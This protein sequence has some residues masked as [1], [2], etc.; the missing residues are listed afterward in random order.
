MLP[1]HRG[2][3]FKTQSNGC[4]LCR[5]VTRANALR[6]ELAAIANTNLKLYA[7]LEALSNAEANISRGVA[8]TTLLLETARLY[9]DVVR[10]A[11]YD[12]DKVRKALLRLPQLNETLRAQLQRPS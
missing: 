10:G 5:P 7:Q 6:T 12:P 4:V 11:G 3:T 1:H 9:S 8:D 2:K